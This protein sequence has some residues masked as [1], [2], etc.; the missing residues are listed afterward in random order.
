MILEEKWI[1]DSKELASRELPISLLDRE[2]C[3][4]EI[5][6]LPVKWLEI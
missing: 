5:P 4:E 6:Y 3:I 2:I 1:N